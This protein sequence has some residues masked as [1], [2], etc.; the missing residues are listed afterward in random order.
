M[1]ATDL[2]ADL[3]AER[4]IA[5][6]PGPDE[7]ALHLADADRCSAIERGYAKIA[8]MFWGPRIPL[9]EACATSAPG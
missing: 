1:T 7:P 3:A 8:P 9:H 2:A 4:D 5:A 6:L